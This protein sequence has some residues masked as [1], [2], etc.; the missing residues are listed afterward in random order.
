MTICG[1]EVSAS[2]VR[3][4]IL[5]GTRAQYSHVAVNPRRLPI[6][7]DENPDEVKAFRDSLYAFL[8]E[9]RVEE[10]AIKKRA[11]RGKYAGGPV[12]FKLEAITQLYSGCPVALVSSQLIA[13]AMKKH[14]PAIPQELREY[15]KTAFAAAFTAL[16]KT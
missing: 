8:R 9:N 2:E 11:K 15:Q 12:G 3:L 5:D 14:A 16:R 1:M 10:V 7:V 6:A 13:A 4:V